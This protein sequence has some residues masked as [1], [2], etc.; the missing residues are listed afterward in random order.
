M[1][2]KVLSCI[3]RLVNLALW[4]LAVI[5]LDL[6]ELGHDVDKLPGHGHV[7]SLLNPELCTGKQKLELGGTYL[8]FKELLLINRS[9]RVWMYIKFFG[10]FVPFS[11]IAT[12]HSLFLKTNLLFRH[13]YVCTHVQVF[14][15]FVGELP[16]FFLKWELFDFIMRTATK[17]E[18]IKT[19]K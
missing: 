8:V 6:V 4:S 5:H 1:C 2:W 17:E 13:T 15:V 10:W 9:W 14:I 12:K 16:I 7:L 11:S 18:K 3:H 19:E